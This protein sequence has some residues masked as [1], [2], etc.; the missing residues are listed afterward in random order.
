MFGIVSGMRLT[1]SQVLSGIFAVC[2]VVA[3]AFIFLDK[4]ESMQQ[5]EIQQHAKLE[6]TFVPLARKDKGENATDV[7]FGLK[8]ENGDYYAL[9]FEQLRWSSPFDHLKT[10]NQISVEGT[11]VPI[12]YISSNTWDAFDIKGIMSIM[13]LTRGPGD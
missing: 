9:D 11:M 3:V 2:V 6:G 1:I 8:T 10:G 5:Q 13:T 4:P 7:R 12:E